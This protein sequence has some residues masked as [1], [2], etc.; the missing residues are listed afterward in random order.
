MTKMKLRGCRPSYEIK[1]EFT[2]EC[3]AMGA[4]EL[5]IREIREDQ[6]KIQERLNEL[7]LE[8]KSAQDQEALVEKKE[9]LQEVPPSEPIPQ[10]EGLT[11]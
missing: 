11:Q 4:A 6:E 1:V 5:R 10:M 8:L 3:A 9:H 2:N 7:K